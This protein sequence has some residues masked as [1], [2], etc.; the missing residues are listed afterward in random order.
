MVPLTN[1]K[2]PKSNPLSFSNQMLKKS[3]NHY[4]QSDLKTAY[5]LVQED[6]FNSLLQA[7]NKQTIKFGN[8]G[9]FTKTEQSLSSKKFGNHVYYKLSFRC[10]SK[11][12]TAF[13]DQLSK[14]YRLK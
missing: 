14:K 5:Q 2:N 12:K 7:K 1:Q 11:L 10:F 9:K 3:T 8:L 6:L 4:T 13:H